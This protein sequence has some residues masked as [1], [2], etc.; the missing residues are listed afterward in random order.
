MTKCDDNVLL[1]VAMLER[2]NPY[3][4][5][6][7][8]VPISK[9]SLTRVKDTILKSLE[10]LNGRLYHVEVTTALLEID[11]LI[12]TLMEDSTFVET[13]EEVK[14]IIVGKFIPALNTL[15]L[16]TGKYYMEH[17]F[18]FRPGLEKLLTRIIDK[19]IEQ[20]FYFGYEKELEGA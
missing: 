12:D 14:E 8:R 4:G 6:G 17:T 18:N 19:S 15:Y 11:T 3:L 20:G 1:A 7:T 2:I 16:E 13:D 10:K 5:I 9:N